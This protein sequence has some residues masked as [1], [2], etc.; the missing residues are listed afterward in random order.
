MIP[1]YSRRVK[2]LPYY[3]LIRTRRGRTYKGGSLFMGKPNL[4]DYCWVKS[5]LAAAKKRK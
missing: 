4:P 5:A 2:R 1:I 3:S